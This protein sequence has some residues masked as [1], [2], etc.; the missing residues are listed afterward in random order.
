MGG[1]DADGNDADRND[2]TGGDRE[3]GPVA[4]EEIGPAGAMIAVA[5]TGSVIAFA[6]F[7]LFVLL[8]EVGLVLVA[9][10]LLIVFASPAAYLRY[11]QL[12]P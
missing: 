8:G 10:G 6:G 7:G 1:N 4:P 12:Y 3:P 5:F 11:Q 2:A 9:I